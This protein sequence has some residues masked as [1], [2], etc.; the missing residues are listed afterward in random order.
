[1]EHE[2]AAHKENDYI[3]GTGEEITTDLLVVLVNTINSYPK[4]MTD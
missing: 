4:K 1:M 2:R 3:I